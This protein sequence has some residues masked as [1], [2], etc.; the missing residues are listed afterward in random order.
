MR[1]SKYGQDVRAEEKPA[2]SSA[3]AN[4]PASNNSNDSGS[5]M[6]WIALAAVVAFLIG[7]VLTI[8]G[9]QYK[10][11]AYNCPVTQ[12]TPCQEL[13]STG[14]ALVWTGFV[15]MAPGILTLMAMGM[16]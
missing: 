3:E 8:V 4:L 5:V 1:R 9:W 2:S 11:P 13:S 14:S 7:I 15:L 12:T 16:R 10:Q 6:Q